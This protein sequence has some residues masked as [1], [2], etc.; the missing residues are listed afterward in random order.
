MIKLSI[1]PPNEDDTQR[2]VEHLGSKILEKFDTTKLN[3]NPMTCD[4]SLLPH[5]AVDFDTDIVGLDEDEIRNLLQ[6]SRAIKRYI[7]SKYAVRKAAESIFGKS[8]KAIPFYEYDG[9]PGRYKI[10]VDVTEEKTVT[11]DNL[12]KTK[13][14]VEDANRESC[15]FEGFVITMKIQNKA[16]YKIASML[17][18]STSILPRR[19]ENIV[20]D[21]Q[22]KTL[23][24]SHNIEIAYIKPLG[25]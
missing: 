22:Q 10:E 16:N 25:V 20:L 19:I 15:M 12:L 21:V 5:L 18:E 8:A 6:N 9:E 3:I 14:V 13:K 17:S 4:T 1:L 2:T 23:V 24:A 7:G 11:Q